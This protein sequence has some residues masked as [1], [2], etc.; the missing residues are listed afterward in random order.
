MP[1]SF[2]EGQQQDAMARILG[3]LNPAQREAVSS[4]ECNIMVVAGAGSGKTRVLIHRYAYLVHHYGYSPHEILAVTFTNKA[5]NE[6][7]SRAQELLDLRLS[8]LWIGTFHSTAL[9]VL[10]IHREAAKLPEGFEVIGPSDQKRIITRI[11]KEQKIDAKE[12]PAQEFLSVISQQKEQGQRARNVINRSMNPAKNSRYQEMYRLYEDYCNERGLVDFG[13]MLLRTLELWQDPKNEDI[14]D[15]YRHRF[16]HIL[17]DEYQDTND[18]QAA[19][20][21]TLKSPD[22]H[23]MVVGDDDQAIYGWRGARVENLLGFNQTFKDSKRFTLDQNY[24]STTPILST[25][26]ELI[27]GNAKRLGKNL[28]TDRKEGEPVRVYLA[29]SGATECMY[30]I[31]Q[32][33]RWLKAH[34]LEKFSSVAVLYRN[35]SLSR[36]ME[37]ILTSMDIPFRITGGLQFYARAEIRDALAYMK[38]M[39]DL[40][41]DVSFE[42]VVNEPKRGIGPQ[43]V[44][45][46]RVIAMSQGLS[47]WSA[48]EIFIENATTK[49][50]R[51]RSAIRRF[52]DLIK[53]MRQ[54]C[55]GS[56]LAKIA[57]VCVEDSGLLQRY[58]VDSTETSQSKMENLR[59]LVSACS[60]FNP[61]DVIRT[62]SASIDEDEPSDALRRFLDKTSLDMGDTPVVE[63]NAVN[64]MT[65]HSSKGLEFPLV[66]IIGMEERVLPINEMVVDEERRLVFVGV[67]RAMDELHLCSA[68]SR[69]VFGRT[70]TRAP[71]RFLKELPEE[72]L[73][74]VKESQPLRRSTTPS[75]RSS[76]T[77][78]RYNQQR[79]IVTQTPKSRFSVGE[80]VVH[81]LFGSG[82]VVGERSQGQQVQIRF[83]D[84]SFKWLISVAPKLHKANRNP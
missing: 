5:A 11:M 65:I 35:N 23:V 20:L 46:I 80:D 70:E 44:E 24:R 76:Y 55:Q 77:Q 78:P 40:H 9:R 25:A 30:V 71:S 2:Q 45:L 68:S 13:E 15:L 59:E 19:W 26:N 63:D 18:I 22:N 51:G 41:S 21:Q 56:T 31:T 66:F 57:K 39:D 43:T 36:L 75:I 81:D 6:M 17:V 83:S 72:H 82:T 52:I 10:R 42:R 3:E 4:P 14:L 62:S 47:M 64:L 8:N 60:Q 79:G 48:A 33:R 84:G 32:L 16:R 49:G 73:K 28:W 58:S 37:Q 38:L 61:E 27:R 69:E 1:N 74:R 34:P 29:E 53:S 7:R 67:T 50:Q 54:S 12:T